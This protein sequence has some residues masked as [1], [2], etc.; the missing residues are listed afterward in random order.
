MQKTAKTTPLEFNLPDV[1]VIV[2][3]NDE[4]ID[5]SSFLQRGKE[6]YAVFIHTEDGKTLFYPYHPQIRHYYLTDENKEETYRKIAWEFV[7][8]KFGYLSSSPESET[9]FAEIDLC[10]SA[11]HAIA[12]EHADLGEDRF[13]NFLIQLK[14]IQGAKSIAGLENAF[15]N[16]PAIICGAGPSFEKT[17]FSDLREKALL[18]CGGSA[19]N[20]CSQTSLLPHFTLHFDP[21][22]P[23]DRY[24][25]HTLWEIPFL[26]QLRLNS[27][28][29]D[30][31][32]APSILTPSS[33]GYSLENYLFE[34]STL[35][36][37]WVVGNFAVEVAKQMGCNP[38][39]LVGMDLCSDKTQIYSKGVHETLD[40]EKWIPCT[41]I[42]GENCFTKKD[43]IL[44]ANWME[45]FAKSNPE[46]TCINSSKGLPLDGFTN[47]SID[48]VCNQYLQHDFDLSALVHAK[49]ENNWI[50]AVS[51]ERA[52]STI[53]DIHTSLQSCLKLCSEV[54]RALER[55]YNEVREPGAEVFVLQHD[56]E[57]ELS[58][59]VVIEPTWNIWKNV[60]VR[61]LS[62]KGDGPLSSFDFLINQILF[63]QRIITT[64][65]DSYERVC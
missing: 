51:E 58:Y 3:Y 44:A 29:L 24:A 33:E 40:L 53:Q 2:L 45:E 54:L 22:P 18:F 46:I 7:F 9:I 50:A 17:D 63:F 23:Y 30:L 55:C 10:K 28:V 4:G 43:W 62:I 21:N 20:A 36:S 65:L 37:G 47:L 56:L 26:Y 12:S 34:E 1:N 57:S 48:Q 8:L 14:K 16:V 60:F 31:N 35:D 39:I 11:V 13:Q 15:Q 64:H 19:L 59:K 38:I 42:D 52:V 5:L 27:Q 6:Y 61:N 25:K 41:N 49:L 32:H